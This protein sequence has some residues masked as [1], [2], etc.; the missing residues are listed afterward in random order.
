MHSAFRNNWLLHQTLARRKSDEP[1]NDTHDMPS[2]E[3]LF[4]KSKGQP[5]TFNEHTIQMVDLL[6]VKDGQEIRL[7]FESKEADWRQGVSLKTDGAFNVNGQTITKSIVLWYDTAPRNLLL[8]IQTGT[9]EC[10]V[11]NVWDTG[12]GVIQS[13]H[14]G[15]AMIVEKTAT[16]RRYRCNDGQPDEDFTDLIFNIQLVG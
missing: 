2:F 4:L 16:G 1:P 8:K 14:N 11:K 7:E 15:A 9:G 10:R 6:Y 3:S 12:D 13:W 5:I